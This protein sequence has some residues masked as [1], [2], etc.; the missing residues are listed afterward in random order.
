MFFI[1]LLQRSL[2]LSLLFMIGGNVF[3]ADQH[4]PSQKLEFEEIIHAYLMSK[5]E[6]I[7]E[8]L[9]E[10]SKREKAASVAAQEKV[11]AEKVGIIFNSPNQAVVGNS[12]GDVTLVEFFDYNCGFC[13]KSVDTIT[14][15]ID[16]DP[17][18]RV[19][20]KD[21]PVLGPDSIDAAR[22]ST[23]VRKQLTPQKF[24]KFHNALLSE[25]IHI[26]KT[27]ALKVAKTL[28]ADMALLKKDMES[29]ATTDTLNEVLSL[30]KDLNLHGTPA[31]VIGGVTM[32][33]V[34]VD[35][36]RPV[37][38]F[39]VKINAMRKCRKVVCPS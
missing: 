18:L 15:L 29:T 16:S 1:T 17:M 5:P 33:G 8:A 37:E 36:A 19:V 24:W 6:V 26:G 3:A 10:L 4:T 14:K 28:G 35:G 20:L 11:I 38:D 34:T 12:E 7:R 32:G 25:K 2:L 30:S 31:W 27:D 13:K 39:K 22:V 9:D 21:L 23:A